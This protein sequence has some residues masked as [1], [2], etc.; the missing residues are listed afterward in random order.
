MT[1]P[2]IMIAPKGSTHVDPNSDAKRAG[3]AKTSMDRAGEIIKEH[4]EVLCALVTLYTPKPSGALPGL[5]DHIHNAIVSGDD[6]R[7]TLDQFKD[8]L[9]MAIPSLIKLRV[10]IEE[11][12]EKFETK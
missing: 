11:H 6:D 8:F 5:H 12:P 4:P 2:I 3:L 10:D 7:M 9:D 1:K